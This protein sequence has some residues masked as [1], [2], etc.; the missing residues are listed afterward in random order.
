MR[1]AFYDTTRDDDEDEDLGPSKSE[2]KREAEALQALGKELSELGAETLA[3]IALPESIAEAIADLHKM[4]SFGAKRRQLQL[5]GRL[6]RSLDATSVR[7]AI[8]RATGES[9]AAVAAHHR[10]E[11][12]RD[13]IIQSD[14]ALTQYIDKHPQA[15]T[16]KLRQLARA[17]R[18]EAA[19]SAPPKSARELYRLI[20]ADQL[21]P[22]NLL[23]ADGHPQ[24]EY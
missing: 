11:M 1:K 17:A 5:I 22:L 10:A 2:R 20:Y 14:E 12:L 16:Q 6:M 7:E 15:P 8:D 13:A 4:K 18:R 23:T 9:H 21:P 3:K 19:Q 24:R